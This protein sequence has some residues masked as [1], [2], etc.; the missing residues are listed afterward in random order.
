MDAVFNR[1]SSSDAKIDYK[2]FI[3]E[4]LFREEEIE[5]NS[6]KVKASQKSALKENNDNKSQSRSTHLQDSKQKLAESN[7]KE[8]YNKC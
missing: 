8:I 4:L 3:E 1:Y 5:S 2:Q 6:S 7:I